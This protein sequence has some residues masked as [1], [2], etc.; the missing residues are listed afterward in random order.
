MQNVEGVALQVSQSEQMHTCK[1]DLV[2]YFSYP[3]IKL[4]WYDFF[5][6]FSWTS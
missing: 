2:C 1:R 5:A 4:Y 3:G 6:A